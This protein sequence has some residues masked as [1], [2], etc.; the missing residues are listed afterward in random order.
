MEN[1]TEMK[2]PRRK[3]TK[4]KVK[5]VKLEAEKQILQTKHYDAP[6]CTPYYYY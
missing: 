1:R 6:G 3:Y 2:V 4:P 5:K